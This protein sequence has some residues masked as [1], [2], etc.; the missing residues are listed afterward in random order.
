[1]SRRG[2]GA[3]RPVEADDPGGA[4]VT[5]GAAAVLGSA[6]PPIV[7]R[8]GF[9]A[10]GVWDRRRGVIVV[11]EAALRTWPP[12][13]LT[14]LGAHEATHARNGRRLCASRAHAGLV[15]SVL[16]APIV[17]AVIMLVDLVRMVDGRAPLTMWWVAAVLAG[18][19]IVMPLAQR[20]RRRQERQADT[21]AA[22]TAG[23]AAVLAMLDQ[24]A[25]GE[26]TL[27]PADRRYLRALELIGW[28]THPRLSTR[29]RLITAL[30]AQGSW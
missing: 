28:S 6:V 1:M 17:L 27:R 26:A 30:N 7:A 12:A 11:D 21:V 4:A 8:Q 20:Y 25:R 10:S 3:D 13:A 24:M 14:A 15:G 5:A 2:L 16:L 29:R 22:H 18:F 9:T 23:C 19:A